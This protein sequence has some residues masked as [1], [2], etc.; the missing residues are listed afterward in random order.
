[1]AHAAGLAAGLG[2][3]VVVVHVRAIDADLPAP[4]AVPTGA[5]VVEEDR[6]TADA[7]VGAA[8]E[9]LSAAG[10]TAEAEVAAAMRQDVARTVL[11]LADKHRADLVMTGMHQRGLL[12]SLLGVGDRVARYAGCPVVLVP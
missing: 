12:G 10:V 2:A 8:L 5:T 9:T 3:R 1:V 7:V 11:D 4:G 6:A